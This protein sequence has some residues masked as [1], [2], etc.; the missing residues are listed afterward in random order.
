MDEACR[1][2]YKETCSSTQRS[3]A[4]GFVDRHNDYVDAL[5]SNAFVSSVNVTLTIH[6]KRLITKVSIR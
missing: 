3:T 6:M 5:C 1:R 4:A 2:S